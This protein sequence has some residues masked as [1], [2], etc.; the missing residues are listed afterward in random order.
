[1]PCKPAQPLM[2]RSASGALG[3]ARILR[4]TLINGS[5]LGV[6]WRSSDPCWMPMGS[7]TSGDGEVVEEG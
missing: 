6:A 3:Q 7:S 5:S 1:M 2:V 4:T